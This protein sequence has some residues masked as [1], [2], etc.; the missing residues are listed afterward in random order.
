MTAK[1]GYCL[2]GVDYEYAE[3]KGMTLE[4]GDSLGFLGATI[5]LVFEPATTNKVGVL[6]I[7]DAH[8]FMQLDLADVFPLHFSLDPPDD[9]GKYYH[10]FQKVEVNKKLPRPIQHTLLQTDYLMKSFSVGSDI[11]SIAPFKQR[12]CRDGLTKNLPPNLQEATRS[13]AERKQGT[14]N[15]RSMS[16]F[17]IQAD[18]VYIQIS[19]SNSKIEVRFGDV[20]IKVRSHPI[21]PGPDGHL[22]D[23]AED[24]DPTSPEAGFAADLTNN[25][26][27]LSHYFPEYARLYEFGKLQAVKHLLHNIESSLTENDPSSMQLSSLQKMLRKFKVPASADCSCD[28]VPAALREEHTDISFS[29]CYGGV[30]FAPRL[31]EA[32]VPTFSKSA[33]SVPIKPPENDDEEGGGL[34]RQLAPMTHLAPRYSMTPSPVV[35]LAHTPT[36]LPAQVQVNRHQGYRETSRP[37]LATST[38]SSTQATNKQQKASSTSRASRA[39]HAPST[40]LKSG[41]CQAQ[42][43]MPKAS[44]KQQVTGSQRPSLTPKSTSSDRS[45]NTHKK[46]AVQSLQFPTTAAASGHTTYAAFTHLP[47][48]P[49]SALGKFAI[50]TNSDAQ[51][52]VEVPTAKSSKIFLNIALILGR[53]FLQCSQKQVYETTSLPNS[54]LCDRKKPCTYRDIISNFMLRSGFIICYAT[55][56]MYKLIDYHLDCRMRD[57]V[58]MF[59]IGVLQI[60]YVGLTMQEFWVRMYQHLTDGYKNTSEIKEPEMRNLAQRIDSLLKKGSKPKKEV[61]SVLKKLDVKIIIL[62]YVNSDVSNKEHTLNMLKKKEAKLIDLFGT[63]K[64]GANKTKGHT[65]KNTCSEIP[66]NMTDNYFEIIG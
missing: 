3:L 22:R 5:K 50:E 13:I 39:S 4:L 25:Y 65:C 15:S 7:E 46:T 33:I 59:D 51:I 57:V 61:L 60:Q 21:I 55:G 49:N 6:S 44:S 34:L 19:Y 40:V 38:C 62:S 37:S 26:K 45:V 28:W 17:W 12:P 8:S 42:A 14:G 48:V 30:L 31:T 56:K 64:H 24:L 35:S 2:L 58:Y 16:R 53:S 29:R 63:F 1:A 27:E 66:S 52:T 47:R 18:K 32:D 10:P 11:S 41:T 54:C 20:D 43:N 23:T 9:T 36:P